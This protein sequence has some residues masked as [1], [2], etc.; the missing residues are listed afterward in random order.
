MERKTG[1]KGIPP[2]SDRGLGARDTK[3]KINCWEFM[4]CG[5]ELG[6]KRAEEVGVCPAA[7][8]PHADGVNG[9]INGGRICWAVVGIYS[10]YTG[11]SSLRQ[12]SHNCF[13]CEFHKMVLAEEETF[14]FELKKTG[15][16][17]RRIAG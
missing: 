11:K 4:R 14:T 6:G 12:T 2:S 16:K 1:R 9:G 7:I 5:R 13:E 8:D 17:R 10:C 3:K 15:R